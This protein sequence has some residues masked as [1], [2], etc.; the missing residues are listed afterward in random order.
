MDPRSW[1]PPD[2]RSSGTH[3]NSLW[4]HPGEGAAGLEV[5]GLQDWGFRIFRGFGVERIKELRC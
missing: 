4:H 2:P 5:Q 1:Q 3:P